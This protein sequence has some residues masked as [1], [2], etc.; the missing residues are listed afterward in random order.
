VIALSKIGR[1][2]LR[3]LARLYTDM[4]A[5]AQIETPNVKVKAGAA[6]RYLDMSH[7]IFK[8]IDHTIDDR[9]ANTVTVTSFDELR[10][11]IRQRQRVALIGD[12][13]AGKTTT[14]ERLAYEL[15]TAAAGDESASLSVFMRLDGFD[16][17]RKSWLH[18][19][20]FDYNIPN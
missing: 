9:E 3:P 10:E 6:A 5:Q 19:E 12:P 7:H 13:G 15:A 17:E 4:A 11:G 16:A 18:L 20:N 1:Q 14:L 2:A 8:S